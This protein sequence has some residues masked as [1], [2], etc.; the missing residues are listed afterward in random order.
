VDFGYSVAIHCIDASGRTGCDPLAPS[1]VYEGMGMS[2]HAFCPSLVCFAMRAG[3]E[4]LFIVNRNTPSGAV[5]IVEISP[6][7]A[8]I[9]YLRITGAIGR[10]PAREVGLAYTAHNDVIAIVANSIQDHRVC[11]T[12]KFLHYEAGDEI[13]VLSLPTAA[14]SGVFSADGT[15]FFVPIVSPD[16][17]DFSVHVFANR[18]NGIG[19]CGLTALTVHP[20][21]DVSSI[22]PT[23][24]G[25]CIAALNRSD[26]NSMLVYTD[27]KGVVQRTVVVHGEVTVLVRMEDDVCCR[28]RDG[29]VHVICEEW[30]ASLRCAWVTACVLY[31]I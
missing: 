1:I 3:V 21:H 19:R 27:Q 2:R 18:S 24:D 31:N 6:A 25:G 7:G 20:K 10:Q 16:R 13:R 12:V 14:R 17:R 29:T 8:F 11:G 15:R 5:G 30:L 22:L 4:T 26:K 9:R 28:T 23:D